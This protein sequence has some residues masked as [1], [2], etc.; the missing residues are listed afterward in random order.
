[1]THASRCRSRRRRGHTLSALLLLAAL[2]APAAAATAP[3][4]E[5]DLVPGLLEARQ[6]E[7]AAKEQLARRW[8]AGPGRAPRNQNAYDVERY[9]LSLTLSP[10]LHHL[11][12][13]LTVTA[14]VTGAA[15]ATLELDLAGNM[16]VSAATAGGQPAAFDHAGDLLTVT[17]DR[18]YQAGERVTVT[19]DYGG[20]PT[21]GVESGYFGWGSHAGQPMIWTKSEP[22]GAPTWWPCKDLTTDKADSLD[23]RVTVPANLVVAAN[24]LLRAVIDAGFTKT[25][26]WHSDYPICTYLV[27]FAAYPYSSYTDWYAPQAGGAAMPVTHYVFPDWWADSAPI[28]A[29][30]VPMLD[31]FAP[32]FGEYP[33]VAEKY[34]HAHFLWGGGMEHQTLTSIKGWW[35]DGVSHELAHQW[36]GDAVTCADFGHIWLNEGFASWAEAFW[37]EHSR[38]VEMYQLYMELAAYYGEGT[39][40]VEDP[41]TEPIF[42]HH[43]AYD[44]A[45]WVVHM[46]RRR[47]GDAAFFAGLRSYLAAQAYGTATTEQFRDAM[48]AASG[49]ELDAFFAQWI[50]GDGCP[51]YRY[52]WEPGPGGAGVALTIEQLQTNAG[53]FAMPIDVRVT[54]TTGSVQGFTVQNSQLEEAYL[55]PATGQPAFVQLDPEGWIL[56]HARSPLTAP[57][58]DRGILLVNAVHWGLRK[59]EIVTAY[60]ANAFTGALPISFWDCFDAWPGVALPANL[61]PALG[62]GAVPGEVLARYSTVVWIADDEYGDRHYWQETPL[63]DYLVAGGNLLV[64]SRH[65]AQLLTEEFASFAGI[66][67]AESG[68]TLAAA[69]AVYPGLVDVPLTNLQ[70]GIDVFWPSL[71]ANGTLLMVDDAGFPG[72]R[73]IGVHAQAPGGGIHRP[74]GAQLVYL[75]ARPYRLD[76]AATR[77]DCAFILE[78]FFGEP[79][80][81]TAA[82]PA[83]AAAALALAPGFP[84]PFNPQ[85]TLRFALPA[86]GAAELA[87][88]AVNGR[89]LRLLMHGAQPAGPQERRWDGCDEAGRALPSGLY[90][91]R[92][93]AGSET[94][95]QRLLLL[96]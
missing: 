28:F 48:E 54:S 75:A 76:H 1:M 95:V 3:G 25:Y 51:D 94:R 17:L 82:P 58:F 26:H 4:G 86:A 35:E 69:S 15:L 41:L 53:P 45:S 34:G 74:E 11:D 61:P 52:H 70:D 93:S 71:G 20:D 63:Y 23:L 60:A 96:H 39:I 36:F 9:D 37:M 56:C 40:F 83:P 49:Q 22:Y 7:A 13:S 89:R 80:V 24:G 30:T 43:L 33:F 72:S 68:A 6:E 47:L 12:G 27:A 79:W 38:H 50:Y 92:L 42:D 5:P 88:L 90:L 46:L 18:V 59:Q 21:G 14:T 85:T 91:A 2:L 29:K 78:H 16:A 10:A 65:G 44:K 57:S 87:I 55:L 77:T 66:D 19:V 67:W 81:A 62:H 32:Y 31:L 64:I 8:Q 73:G 84:N